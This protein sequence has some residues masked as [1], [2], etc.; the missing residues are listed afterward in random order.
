MNLNVASITLICAFIYPKSG[1]KGS[2]IFFSICIIFLGLS[3]LILMYWYRLGDLD[4]KFLRMIYF[5]AIMFNLLCL[6]ANLSIHE[7]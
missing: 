6:C 2:N 7:V 4:P 5:N 1:L 3:H